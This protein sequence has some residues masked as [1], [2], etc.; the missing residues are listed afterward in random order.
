MADSLNLAA[1]GSYQLKE[2]GKRRFYAN[3]V[4]ILCEILNLT[5]D[6]I[7]TDDSYEQEE[8]NYLQCFTKDSF[9]IKH[10]TRKGKMQLIVEHKSYELSDTFYSELNI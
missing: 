8:K 1:R 2:Q 6:E 5:F 3:E 9:F 4:P 10:R 7:Y